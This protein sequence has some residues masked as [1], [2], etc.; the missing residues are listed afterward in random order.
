MLAVIVILAVLILVALPA[1]TNLMTRARKSALRTEA[2]D[3]ARNGVQL[4]YSANML[5]GTSVVPSGTVANASNK[6]Y[7]ITGGEYLCMTFAELVSK[8][9]IEKSNT[10]GYNGH[11]SIFVDNAGKATMYIHL[12]NGTYFIK[13]SYTDLAN[14]N[15]I[16]TAV[17]ATKPSGYSDPCPSISSSSGSTI[18][19][20]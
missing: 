9:Y 16:D 6:V 4:A 15:D 18:I 2:L 14:N 17:T 7:K 8:G 1:V 19:Q 3:I 20:S 5:S 10:T 12:T 13:S 11:V